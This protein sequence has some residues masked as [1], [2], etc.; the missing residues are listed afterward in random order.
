MQFT[1]FKC[2]GMA[3][4]LSWAH[5][6]GDPIIASKF[7]SVWGQ[8]LAG[9]PL[10]QSI[11]LPITNTRKPEKPPHVTGKPLPARPV[12]AEAV[13]DHWITANNCKMEI[14][15]FH[16]TDTRLK[17]IK[18]KISDKT[19]PFEAISALIW[20][21]LAKIRKER[22]PKIVT[23]CRNNYLDKDL[24]GVLSNGQMISTVEADFHLAKAELPELA[25]LI[26]AGKN[27]ESKE[28]EA[29]VD[30][31]NGLPD[32]IIY[33]ANLTFV[34]LE[35]VDLYGLELKGQKPVSVCFAIEG[36]GDEGVVLVLQG[37]PKGIITAGEG[38]D[39]RK[40]TVILPEN[41]VLQL[42]DALEKD[43]CIT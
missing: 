39:G 15:S 11:Q 43:W 6:L 10:H 9:S 33:G 12:E 18:S 7:I 22:G 27:D 37:P 21:C 5:V 17:N 40:V 26:A 38:G 23:V 25:T 29:M 1:K 35:G 14:H 24:E 16:F 8:H 31:D 32:L 36:I 2:G 20:Q 42:R 34:D 19:E 4:G 13:G 30:Y 41:E 3:I 28:I